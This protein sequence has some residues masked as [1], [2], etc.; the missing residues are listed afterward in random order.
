MNLQILHDDPLDILASTKSV[1]EQARFVFIRD[2]KLEALAGSIVERFNKGLDSQELGF[3]KADSIEDDIQLIF[4]EDA[5]NF[6]FWPDKDQ[7]KWEVEWPGGNIASGGWYG[8]VACFKRGL[9]EKIPILDADYLS[10]ITMEQA[11]RFFRGK[12]GAEIPLLRERVSNLQEAGKVLREKFHGK[13]ANVLESCGY[14]SVNI[15]NAILDN[16]PSFRDISLLRGQEVRLLK[17][18]QIC[19]NDLAYVLKET[20][21]TITNFHKLTAYADYKLPQVLRTFGIFEY[22]ASLAER[23]DNFIEIPHDSDEEIEIRAATVWAIELLRQ[24]IG[25][26][27]AGEIDNAIWLM[28]QD[29]QGNAKPYHRTRTIFY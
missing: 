28:S 5:V 17:R 29:I 11:R 14:D 23:I 8:L 4:I 22:E 1:V 20:G 7:L 18:A 26:L 10:A 6:C 2:N 25:R 13:F 12:T 19:P 3:G 27:T 16:F 21:H 15:V 24:M 9:A